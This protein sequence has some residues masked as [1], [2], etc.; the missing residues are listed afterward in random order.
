MNQDTSLHFQAEIQ[1]TLFSRIM[2]SKF[3][4]N[5]A[6]DYLRENLRTKHQKLFRFFKKNLPS[7]DLLVPDEEST[8]GKQ[9]TFILKCIDQRFD[10]GIFVKASD[11]T[12][13]NMEIARQ[14]P[15]PLPSVFLKGK[16]FV[17]QNYDF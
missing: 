3:G 6:S 11:W 4:G 15:S 14:A 7:Q 5:L 10:A 2:F 9:F 8:P 1:E 17:F 16:I 12:S 13:S